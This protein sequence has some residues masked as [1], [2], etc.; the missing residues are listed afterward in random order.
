PGRGDGAG[1]GLAA[2]HVFAPEAVVHRQ[3]A[4]QPVHLHARL[5]GEAAAPQ[6]QGGRGVRLEL[7]GGV[8]HGSLTSGRARL[9]CTRVVHF[10]TFCYDSTVPAAHP[11]VPRSPMNKRH[12][13][14]LTVATFATSSSAPRVRGTVA[15]RE[16]TGT[17]TCPAN[18][19]D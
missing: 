16:N 17:G 14:A 5:G 4:V 10:P 19:V 13:D 3:R 15:G 7:K 8:G 11:P 12:P 1:P 2:G 6:A 9:A 18:T